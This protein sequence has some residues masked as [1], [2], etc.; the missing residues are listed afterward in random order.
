MK[1]I[2]FDE[3]LDYCEKIYKRGDKVSYSEKDKQLLSFYKK[4]MTLAKG[5]IL[6]LD[7]DL[8]ELAPILI[9]SLDELV[10]DLGNLSINSNNYFSMIKFQSINNNYRLVRLNKE[11]FK[12]ENLRN[13][14]N[15]LQD[16]RDKVTGPEDMVTNLLD[17]GYLSFQERLKLF[18]IE[19]E[20]KKEKIADLLSFLF[21]LLSH[22]VHTSTVVLKT[23]NTKNFYCDTVAQLLLLSSEFFAVAIEID[24]S[25]KFKRNRK[26]LKKCY[27]KLISENDFNWSLNFG[28]DYFYNIE[29]SQLDIY[30]YQGEDMEYDEEEHE[31]D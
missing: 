6:V 23:H 12:S 9:R 5:V 29:L 14:T 17:K 24:D 8:D 31:V 21:Y 2:I 1:K 13:L 19:K 16:A 11:E 3:M 15:I 25:K 28:E 10:L 20:H 26:K 18:T 27:K 22:Y 7:N 4:C 30:D